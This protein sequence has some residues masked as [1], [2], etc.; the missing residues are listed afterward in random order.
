MWKDY[1][2]LFFKNIFVLVRVLCHKIFDIS[3]ILLFRAFWSMS[4]RVWIWTVS[5]L[6][7]LSFATVFDLSLTFSLLSLLIFKQHTKPGITM[8]NYKRTQPSPHSVSQ[9]FLFVYAIRLQ[10]CDFLHWR[11][12]FSKGAMCKDLKMQR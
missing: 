1:H 5:Y 2:Q 12:T 8:E 7:T 4:F 6:S 10:Y 3:V 9:P 11:R